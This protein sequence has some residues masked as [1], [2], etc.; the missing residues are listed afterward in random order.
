MGRFIQFTIIAILLIIS[1]SLVVFSI[2]DA[3]IPASILKARE[4]SSPSD[5]LS[6]EHIKVYDDKVILNVENPMWATFTDTNSMDPFIDENAH[7]IEI[8]P[9][10][11][12]KINIGDVISYKTSYGVIIHRVI[13]KGQD[14]KGMYYLVKGD[15]NQ[16]RDPLKVRFEDVQGVVVAVIY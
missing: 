5:W 15:N 12:D 3:Q 8:M 1:T 9:K 16:L 11:P 4:I 14:K 7:A 2:T 10:S 13:E 6:S